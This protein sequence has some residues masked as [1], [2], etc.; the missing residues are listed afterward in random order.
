VNRTALDAH[1]A[2]LHVDTNAIIKMATIDSISKLSRK[3]FEIKREKVPRNFSI[4]E[5]AEI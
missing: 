3:K 2:R 1:I 4:E 5:N